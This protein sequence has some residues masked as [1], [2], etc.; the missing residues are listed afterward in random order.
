MFDLGIKKTLAYRTEGTSV[1]LWHLNNIPYL[2]FYK[3]RIITTAPMAHPDTAT[4][5]GKRRFYKGSSF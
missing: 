1:H 3:I 5:N 4:D 2:L